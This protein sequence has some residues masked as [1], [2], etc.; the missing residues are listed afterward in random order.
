M[1]SIW[2]VRWNKVVAG[3]L[4]GGKE[5]TISEASARSQS[6]EPATSEAAEILLMSFLSTWQNKATDL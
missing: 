6:P 2:G 1:V 3:L 4:E 5:R